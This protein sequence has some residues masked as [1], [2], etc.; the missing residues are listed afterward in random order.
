MKY[1]AEKGYSV[2]AKEMVLKR[3]RQGNEI[4]LFFPQQ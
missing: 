3:Q 1:V 4:A 2:D